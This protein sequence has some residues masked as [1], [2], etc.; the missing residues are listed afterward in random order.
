MSQL[1]DGLAKVADRLLDRALEEGS[2]DLVDA[3]SY[4]LPVIA[5][6]EILGVPSEDR[7]LFRAWSDLLVSTPVLS[8]FGETVA[9]GAREERNATTGGFSRTSSVSCGT[10]SA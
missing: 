9:P 3:L 5:I 8:A 7:E 1:A 10:A 2:V 4:P 6:S